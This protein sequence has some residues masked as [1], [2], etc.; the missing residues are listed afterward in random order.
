[1]ADA[2]HDAFEAVFLPELPNLYSAA[3][4]Y[5]RNAEDAEDLVQETMLKAFRSFDPQRPPEFPRAW[6]QKVLRNEAID[7]GRRSDRRPQG[8]SYDAE[9]SGL[10][11]RLQA[12]VETGQYSDP[13]RL[14]SRWND[15]DAVREVFEELAEPAREILV[16][17]DVAGLRYA[18]ISEV[19]GVPEG[20]VMSR[21]SRARRAFERAFA[22]HL[23]LPDSSAP[24]AL[25]D[26]LAD[27]SAALDKLARRWGALPAPIEA[28]RN[29]PALLGLAQSSLDG[30]LKATALDA[31]S[32]LSIAEAACGQ[33]APP[34]GGGPDAALRRFGGAVAAHGL[35]GSEVELSA[36]AEDGLDEDSCRAAAAI[37][38]GASH[39]AMLSGIGPN[40][41]AEGALA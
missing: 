10:Y 6:L 1:M 40:R 14:I 9:S 2:G 24:G 27:A 35:R 38:A 19:L 5:A 34:L 13:L 11:E 41:Q 33:L 30:M 12:G 15:Q 32:A 37:A 4:R 16:L 23:D 29:D 7:S 21:L 39:A 18:E 3:R 31:A 25:E 22:E 17:A 20:T 36:L 26:A 28:L 8:V